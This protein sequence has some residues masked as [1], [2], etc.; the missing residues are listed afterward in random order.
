MRAALLTS[1]LI[2]SLLLAATASTA[3]AG[4]VG[5]AGRPAGY[6][7]GEVIV[8]FKPGLPRAASATAL[9]AVGARERRA[10]PTAGTVLVSVP[11]SETVPAAVRRFERDPRV[12]W[13]TP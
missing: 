4:G 13:A 11:A 8:K 10:L 7:P 6:V 1:L 5:A 12:A 3:A 9:R 2:V